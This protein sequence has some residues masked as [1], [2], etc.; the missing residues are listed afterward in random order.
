MKCKKIG[1]AVCSNSLSASSSE[2]VEKLET[3]LREAGLQ[4]V[5]SP[6]IYNDEYKPRINGF[7]R[8]EA[9]MELFS[10]SEISCIFD[11]SGGD[12]ANEVI[13]YLDFNLIKGSKKTF[14]GYSDLTT[15]VNSIYSRTGS[16][17]VLYQIRNIAE[18]D[19]RRKDFFDFI[20]NSEER[21]FDFPYEFVKGESMSGIVVGGNIR[22]FLKLA[23]TNCFPD[24]NGKILLLEAFGGGTMQMITYFSQLKMLGAFEKINGIVLGTFT[25]FEESQSSKAIISL[26]EQFSG[27]V[28][29]VKTRFIGHG[30][31]SYAV[32]IGQ[33]YNFEK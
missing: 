5:F 7:Q 8:A 19:E 20:H 31:D 33:Y 22:C 23:G 26:I 1:I 3:I 6:Y 27:N 32:K 21:L 30:V 15:I 14:W 24:L 18:C 25:K 29:I 13:P 16:S 9:L 11:I 4:P 12:I 28:P 2:Y 10:N 17:A